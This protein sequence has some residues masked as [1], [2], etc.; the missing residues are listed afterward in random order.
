M[1]VKCVYCV[2][3]FLN[4]ALERKKLFFY[5]DFYISHF[6]F[7]DLNIYSTVFLIIVID[8]FILLSASSIAGI[9][10]DYSFVWASKPSCFYFY[11][12]CDCMQYNRL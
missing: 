3:F 1:F 6:F 2:P 7:I 9:F 12:Y 5:F 4:G 11:F 8:I 10:L